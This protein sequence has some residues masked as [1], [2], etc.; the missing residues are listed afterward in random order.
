[1]PAGPRRVNNLTL[2]EGKIFLATTLAGDIQ[3]AGSPDVGFFYQDTRFLSHLEL[4]VNGHRTV[5]LSA[6]ARANQA[7][8]IDLTTRGDAARESLDLPDNTVHIRR[9]QVLGGRLFDRLTVENYQLQP[10]SLELEYRFAADFFDVFQVRG[11]RRPRGGEYLPSQVEADSVRFA[12][13]GLDG[14]TRETRLRFHPAPRCLSAAA[15]GYSLRL[16]PRESLTIEL[17]IEPRAEG[18]PPAQVDSSLDAARQR[19]RNEYH[20][21]LAAST[22]LESSDDVWNACW[23]TAVSDFFALRIPAADTQAGP[24]LAA[25][26]PW[27]ATPFG[28][29]SLLAGYQALMLQP[30]LA[31]DILRFLARYQGRRDCERND[32]Q[33]GKIMHELRQGEMTRTGEM[34]FDPYYGSIDSTPL[35]LILLSEWFQW[36]G[37]VQL[38]E[39]L[40]PAARRAVAWIDRAC[41]AQDG[42]L[43]YQ[44]Q[45]ERGLVNQG[46]KDSW[47]AILHRNGEPASPPIA[48]CEV[49]GYAYDARYRWSR[50]LRQLGEPAEAD[51]QRRQAAEFARR[52]D[53]EFWLPEERYYALA[54]DASPSGHPPGWRPVRGVAS[55][56]GHLLWSRIAPAEHAR[57]VAARLLREGMFSGWGVRTLAAD[58]P[59][60]N[61]LSY[62]RGSVW[63]H[64][65][66]L[67]AHGLALCG[68]P[69]PLERVFTGLF[70]AARFF[71]DYRLPELFVGVER[72]E[73]DEPV[74]YPVSCSPQ[75]WASGA[76]FLLLTS[77]LGLRPQA[78]RHELHI[79]NPRL[80]APLDWLRLNHLQVGN[81]RVSLEFSR[82]GHR[83]FCNLLDVQGDPLNV[84]LDFRP[85]RS[86]NPPVRG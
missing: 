27:F 24:A 42:W 72:R 53:R 51:R 47:D 13:R 78:V 17:E 59:V 83:T 10:A 60:F 1:M 41:A 14:V 48:L 12:Y 30:Q 33:P 29:D 5:V 77:L 19:R 50:L 85:N 39:E 70:Q 86:I 79:V 74:P 65:N 4:C 49:Q 7:S 20:R 57:A 84:T 8:Q 81:S 61:P 21:W 67:L 2:L 71:R 23:E 37:N 3:P 63:P 22:S 31:A 76:W 56:A 46:W 45:A 52:F 80:P 34:P 35:F 43:A 54:L 18:R 6:S 9:E 25:G 58:E 44:R 26:I 66:S 11:M 28:R 64:D 15:A 82:R 68:F 55:N 38:L 75:A 73:W 36:T 62:H 40:A 69:A 16:A 32:E